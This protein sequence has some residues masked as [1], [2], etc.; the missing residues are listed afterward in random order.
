M[1]DANDAGRHAGQRLGELLIAECVDP[2]VVE[3]PAGLTGADGAPVID[4]N[5]WAQ[6]EPDW[7]TQLE[8]RPR[9]PDHR[10][11]DRPARPSSE[12]STTE[13]QRTCHTRGVT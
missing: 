5:A 2:I 1:C 4:L 3:P 9:P 12:N 8:R 7:A 6:T 11:A 13:T 10:P